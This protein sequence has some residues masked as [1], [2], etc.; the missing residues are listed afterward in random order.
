MRSGICPKCNTPT[1][2]HKRGGIGFGGGDGVYVYTSWATRASEADHYICTNCGFFETYVAN[3]KKL[4]EVTSAW[5]KVT[6]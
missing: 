3:E 1:V 5:E 6:K 2:Y 4:A